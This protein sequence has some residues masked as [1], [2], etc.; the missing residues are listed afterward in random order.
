MKKSPLV[1]SFFLLL[2][3]LIGEE[4]CEN[5][6]QCY[7][8]TAREENWL[9]S[10]INSES[11]RLYNSLDCEGKNRALILSKTFQN[12]NLAI[13]EAAKEMGQRQ[14]N[15]YPNQEDYNEFIEEQAG[16]DPFRRRFGY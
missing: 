12:K 16:Q 5:E 15:E 2:S 10:Q 6:Q 8:P 3:P 1:I 4:C 9:F 13:Q 11:R 7:L 14:K